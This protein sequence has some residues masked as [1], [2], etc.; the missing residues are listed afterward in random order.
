MRPLS[1]SARLRCCAD[2]VPPGGTVAD[3]GCDHGYLSIYLL[4]QGLAAHIVATDLRE[5]PLQRARENA[6]LHGVADRMDFLRTS[7]LQGV[8]TPCDTVIAAGM[9]GDKIAEILEACPWTRT[10][11]VTLV[12]QPQTS[13]N[14]LR[15]YLGARGYAIQ[16]ERLTKDAGRLY[17]AMR[18]V[19]GGGRP[20]SPGE[21]FVSPQ[22][23]A[24]GSPLLP[25]YFDRVLAGLMRTLAGMAQGTGPADP[26]EDYYRTALREVKEMQKSYENGT[27]CL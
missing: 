12:L 4:Q 7:G 10:A 13:G 15:R 19:Y 18:T 1:I 8:D 2:L 23:L 22:L 26:R 5:K 17:F 11:P 21:Q 9:G 27:G 6:A 3:V 20:L 25:A 14:D 24:S 16:E